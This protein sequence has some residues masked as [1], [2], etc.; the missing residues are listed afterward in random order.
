MYWIGFRSVHHETI[1]SLCISH[2]NPQIS[3]F[4][5][6][7]PYFRFRF[8]FISQTRKMNWHSQLANISYIG[9]KRYHSNPTNSNHKIPYPSYPPT[10]SFLLTRQTRKVKYNPS[11]QLNSN[12]LY[13]NPL[14]PS[15]PPYS[16]NP[17]TP[18][19]HTPSPSS[20]RFLPSHSMDS[21][22]TYQRRL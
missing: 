10:H 15:P 2:I 17:T 16:L 21:F 6:L 19:P 12:Q 13:D 22:V 7:L 11:P 18:L 4:R 14:L 8:H 3:S 9:P 1:Q 5:K 20:P